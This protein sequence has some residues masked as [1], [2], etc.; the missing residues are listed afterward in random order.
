[1]FKVS[2]LLKDSILH[3]LELNDQI[4]L[5]SFQLLKSFLSLLSPSSHSVFLTCLLTNP[6]AVLTMLLNHQAGKPAVYL[7]TQEVKESVKC[8]NMYFKSFLE[9]RSAIPQ[10][11]CRGRGL[12]QPCFAICP[13]SCLW[14]AG[15]NVTFLIAV[16]DMGSF[17]S[18]CP[19]PGRSAAGKRNW[20]QAL[21]TLAI[22]EPPRDTCV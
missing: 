21:I 14:G 8:G 2:V 18:W 17:P 16:G 6:A 19:Q 15:R 1:M 22:K 4:L 11:V 9:V 20:A 13:A 7:G 12:S 3:F 10:G 5:F